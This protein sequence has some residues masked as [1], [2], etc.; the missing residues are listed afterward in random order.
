MLKSTIVLYIED[1]LWQSKLR[2]YISL[3]KFFEINRKKIFLFKIFPIIIYKYI[4]ETKKNRQI[5]ILKYY[6]KNN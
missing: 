1:I 3:F 4:I 2:K 6:I 5:Y